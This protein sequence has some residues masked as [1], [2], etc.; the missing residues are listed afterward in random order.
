ML[1]FECMKL[2]WSNKLSFS[3][4]CLL[5]LKSTALGSF[6]LNLQR[7]G[8]RNPG[9]ELPRRNHSRLFV[10]YVSFCHLNLLWFTDSQEHSIAPVSLILP[11]KLKL[12]LFLSPNT[13][14]EFRWILMA[15]QASLRAACPGTI[16][17]AISDAGIWYYRLNYLLGMMPWK[18][19][20]V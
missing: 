20:T 15:F 10:H 6:G 3:Y 7:W 5:W 14:I 13:S 9:V 11:S 8:I 19:V 18:G 4:L 2:W 17:S 1:A 16:P 12:M